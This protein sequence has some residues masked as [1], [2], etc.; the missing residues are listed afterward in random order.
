MV[1]VFKPR[2][3]SLF[4]TYYPIVGPVRPVLASQFAE[5]Q[6]VG[7][8]TKD[9][10]LIA[11]SWIISDQRG[12]IGIKDMAEVKDADRCWWSTC[13]VGYKGHIVLPVLVTDAGNP[14]PANPAVIR[15]YSNELYVAFG[16]SVRKWVEGSSSWGSSLVTLVETPTDV[17]VHKSKLYYACGSDFERFDGSTWTDGATLG[18]AQKSRYFIEWDGKLF[19]LDNDGQL[20]Y[21]TDEGVTWTA[22]ALSTLPLGYFTSLFLY[23]NVAGDIIIYMGTKQGLYALDFTNAKWIETELILPFHDYAC[24]GATWWR[25]A[26]YIPSG[27]AVYQ[28]VTSNPAVVSLMGMD[29]DYGLPGDYIGNIFKLLPGHNALYAL[30]DATSLVDQDLYPAG[31]YGD[32]QIYDDIGFGAVM[33]WSGYGWSVVYLSG[34][35]ATKITA[36]AICTADDIYRLWFGADN[37]VFYVPLQVTIQNPLEV[38]DF[39]FGASGEHIT[40]W[41]D[42]DNAVVDKLGNQ[43]KAYV[44]DASAT[45]YIMLYYGLDYD[46][47]TWTLFTNSS[48]PDGQIDS[49]GEAEFTFAS[50]AGLS[51]KAIRFKAELTRGS[52]TTVSPD[53]RWL[54]LTYIKLLDTKWGFS[55]R[56]DCSRN[57]RFKNARS[58]L[59]SLKTAVATQ[60]LGEFTFKNGNGSETHRVRIADMQG[61]EVGGKKSEG[62]YEVMLVAP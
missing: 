5:K 58:L 31:Q 46:D 4:G 55:L 33:K 54:R 15:E 44:K 37:K 38:A 13:E 56:V 21:S 32:T 8:Y 59:S 10:E 24:H 2:E 48:F 49:D 60:T 18:S 20:D 53:L 28:Y 9:S 27:M 22:S 1:T 19:S 36:G 7:D 23:R 41:F 29:R 11:S 42:A 40:P 34:D 50:D 45:E 16:T 51:F 14:T 17:I 26:S 12:G 61:V 57:Y 39:D 35:T 52:T 47:D 6:V 43:F 62:Q 3:I 25:D 30:L